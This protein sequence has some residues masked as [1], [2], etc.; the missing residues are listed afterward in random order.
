MDGGPRRLGRSSV[1]D[2]AHPDSGSPVFVT[3]TS[4]YRSGPS[5]RRTSRGGA[6]TA[7]GSPVD[8]PSMHR[9]W[10]RG[11]G[12][13]TFAIDALARCVSLLCVVSA[14]SA[15]RAEAPPAELRAEGIEA[16]P[17]A[18]S[19]EPTLSAAEDGVYLSWLERAEVGHR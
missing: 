12:R 10:M 3:L 5:V 19:G 11:K 4:K 1:L 7:M 6:L 15:C 8:I 13:K 2:L 16:P 18:D 14:G 17:G 9:P